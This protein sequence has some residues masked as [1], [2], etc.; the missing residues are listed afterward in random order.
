MR[1]TQPSVSPGGPRGA[2]CPR[3]GLWR[4]GRCCGPSGPV[5]VALALFVLLPQSPSPLIEGLLGAHLRSL[6]PEH[7][8]DVAS[9]DHHTVKPWFA[10]HTDVSP[11]VENF[12]PQG[13]RLIGGRADYVDHQR[14]AVLV[15][16]HGA[17]VINV[18]TWSAGRSPPPRDATRNGYHLLFW[19][20]SDIDY[21][22]VSDTG[23]GELRGLERLIEQRG[24]GEVTPSEMSSH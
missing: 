20:S 4:L 22:A 12:D 21:C 23:W 2:L 13:Y 15:Y 1:P 17:H 18:F 5:A 19:R 14:A 10:G 24:A 6:M 7:L 16:Q 11:V 8:I 9:S 3:G